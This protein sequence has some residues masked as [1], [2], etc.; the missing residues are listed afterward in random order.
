MFPDPFAEFVASRPVAAVSQTPN[1]SSLSAQFA[2]ATSTTSPLQNIQPLQPSSSS[3]ACKLPTFPPPPSVST[4]FSASHPSVSS[5]L[6]GTSGFDTA[7]APIDK[8]AALAE[9]DRMGKMVECTQASKPS[10]TG[11]FPSVS[12]PP[13]RT[14]PGNPFASSTYNPFQPQTVGM[15]NPFAVMNESATLAMQ[16]N[17]TL[18]PKPTNISTALGQSSFNPFVVSRS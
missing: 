1:Q 4:V 18:A 16:S 11:N 7:S 10:A 12:L 9:L 13:L 3:L 5:S 2:Y 14:Q 6:F 17:T 8:Y 15:N